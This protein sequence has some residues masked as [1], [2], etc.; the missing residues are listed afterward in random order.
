MLFDF[1]QGYSVK[2]IIPESVHRDLISLFRIYLIVGGMPEAVAA[3]VATKSFRDCDIAKESILGTYED[4]FNKYDSRANHQRLLKI[5]KKLPLMV[6]EKFKYVNVDK[7]ERAK[8][9]ARALHMLE[10]A[11][12]AFLVKHSAC[13]GVPILAEVNDKK[14][15]ALFIAYCPYH[16]I[17]L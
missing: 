12:I 3:Y 13:N 15:K 2:T 6:G 10:M 14:F 5:F 7:N 11:R 1:L 4:D 8:P 9:I 17:M 16:R